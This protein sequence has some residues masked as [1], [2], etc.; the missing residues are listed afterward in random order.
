[1]KEKLNENKRSWRKLGKRGKVG[2]EKK[3][4]SKESAKGKVKGRKEDERV[5]TRNGARRRAVR[6]RQGKERKGKEM[7]QQLKKRIR[8]ENSEE[9]RGNGNRQSG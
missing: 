5:R 1:M 2:N 9:W 8:N 3:K 7:H 6:A 4:N